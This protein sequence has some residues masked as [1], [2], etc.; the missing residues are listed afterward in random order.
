MNT[1]NQRITDTINKIIE[2]LVQRKY[3]ELERLCRGCRLT[4]V[5]IEQAIHDYNCELITPPDIDFESIDIIEITNS[6]PRAWSV[7]YDLWTK[8]EG[9][10]DLSL[11]ATLIDN[12][13]NFLTVE[14]DNIHVL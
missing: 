5:E 14:I 10:S 7:R 2:L 8:E 12:G 4:A 13:D 1:V 3:Q 11:E 9:R 6:S